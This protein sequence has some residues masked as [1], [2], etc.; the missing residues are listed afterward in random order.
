MNYEGLPRLNVLVVASN[1]NSKVKIVAAL[2]QLRSNSEV[3]S[4]FAT[5]SNAVDARTLFGQHKFDVLF[6][7]QMLITSPVRGEELCREFKNLDNDITTIIL[8]VDEPD[9]CDGVNMKIMTKD[10]DTV[11]VS[12]LREIAKSKARP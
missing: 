2:E 10:Y 1:N 6:C 7:H 12:Y 8:T 11:F 5:A 3:V 9:D 4:S